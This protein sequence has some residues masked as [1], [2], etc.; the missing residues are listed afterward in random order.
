[1]LDTEKLVLPE[2]HPIFAGNANG[3]VPSGGLDFALHSRGAR[4]G[5][6]CNGILEC[7]PAVQ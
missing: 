2:V 7:K 4:H 6:A 3:F 5:D 1:M